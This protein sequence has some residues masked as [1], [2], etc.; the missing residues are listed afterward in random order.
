[1]NKPFFYVLSFKKTELNLEFSSFSNTDICGDG[2]PV[3]VSLGR[4]NNE[5]SRLLP[6]VYICS[7]VSPVK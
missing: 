3:L 5:H 2:Y 7:T 4:E 6:Y 1:M